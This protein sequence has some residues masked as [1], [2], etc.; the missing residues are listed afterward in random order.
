[1]KRRQEWAHG[2]ATIAGS[3][4]LDQGDAKVTERGSLRDAGTWTGG[5]GKGKI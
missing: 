5:W 4:P 3:F 2:I 1:M